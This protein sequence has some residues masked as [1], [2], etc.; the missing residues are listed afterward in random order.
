MPS[1]ASSSSV[2]PAQAAD[3]STRATAPVTAFAIFASMR[4]PDGLGALQR[5]N[6]ALA[7]DLRTRLAEAR[8]AS[9]YCKI[10]PAAMC[11]AQ[12]AHIAVAF[13]LLGYTSMDSGP[14]PRL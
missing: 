11:P 2:G 5:Q 14:P 6:T 7:Q 10:A 4:P 12:S 3:D 1:D 9:Q 13:L 8:S